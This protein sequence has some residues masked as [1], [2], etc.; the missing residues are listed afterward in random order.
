MSFA[1]S[2]HDFRLRQGASAISL[3]LRPGQLMAVFGPAGSGKSRFVRALCGLER[4]YEGAVKLGLSPVFAGMPEPSRKTTPEAVAKHWSGKRGA[5]LAAEALSAAGLWEKR[6]AAYSTLSPGQQAAFELLGPLSVPS[7]LLVADGQF[8]RMDPWARA[9]S[10]DLLQA[11][12]A[13]GSAGV[14]STGLPEL[15]PLADLVVVLQGESPRFAGSYA[16]LERKVGRFETQV[17]TKNE[18]SVRALCDPFEVRFEEES[19]GLRIT[20]REGQELA[21]RL[22]LEGYGEVESVHLRAPTPGE[23]L[24]AALE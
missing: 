3:A 4:A 9:A 7:G 6:R 14:L 21:A 19:D 5:S 16:E 13:K 1:L 22:L 20:A 8:E 17:R 18:R 23:A 2:L 10:W 12:L 24:R 15:A 11:R